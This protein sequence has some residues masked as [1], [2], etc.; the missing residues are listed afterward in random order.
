MTAGAHGLDVDRHE[1]L[2]L[3]SLDE[4]DELRRRGRRRRWPRGAT[5]FVR[6]EGSCQ[7]PRSAY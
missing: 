5:L 2:A 6:S 3:V 7:F 1:F 4:L